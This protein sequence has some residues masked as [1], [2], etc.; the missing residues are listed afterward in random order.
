MFWVDTGLPCVIEKRAP[1]IPIKH[2]S[3]SHSLHLLKKKLYDTKF[4]IKETHIDIKLKLDIIT[5][6]VTMKNINKKMEG[7]NWLLIELTKIVKVFFKVFSVRKY[8]LILRIKLNQFSS[9]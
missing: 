6:Y 1:I 8:Q 5:M 9:Q 2:M 4:T 7:T 3:S